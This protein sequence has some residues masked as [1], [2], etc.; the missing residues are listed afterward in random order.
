MKWGTLLSAVYYDKLRSI[1]RHYYLLLVIIRVYN[2][3]LKKIAC[4]F[5]DHNLGCNRAPHFI[6][7][8]CM[9]GSNLWNFVLG[10]L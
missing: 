4:A 10:D 5:W 3:F 2:N 8:S 1:A 9:Q 6:L 7:L